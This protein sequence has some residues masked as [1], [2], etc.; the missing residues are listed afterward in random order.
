MIVFDEHMLFRF[1]VKLAFENIADI[2]IAGEASHVA[3]LLG[4]LA[5]TA[6]DVVLLGV[7]IPN[8]SSYIDVTRHIRSDYPAAKILAVA[9]ED[10]F[11]TVQSL[12]DAGINGYIGKRQAN[13]IE[14]EKAIRKVAAGSEYI[15]RIDSNKYYMG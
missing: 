11:N 10:T 9:N 14:L 7:N 1:G 5:Q 3:A 6:V 13:S 2:H 15:G 4:I 8:D 12:M